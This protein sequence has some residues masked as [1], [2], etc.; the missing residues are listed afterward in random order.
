LFWS[1]FG[2]F[3]VVGMLII[4]CIKPVIAACFYNS[5]MK[6]LKQ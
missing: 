2:I 6:I 5:A 4:F 3:V 1:G